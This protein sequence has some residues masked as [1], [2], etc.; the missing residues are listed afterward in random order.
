MER[1]PMMT[2]AEM[3]TAVRNMAR[4]IDELDNDL[5]LIR[6]GDD[7]YNLAEMDERIAILEGKLP[8]APAS[9]DPDA[10]VLCP[11]CGAPVRCENCDKMMDWVGPAAAIVRRMRGTR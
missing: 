4:K 6:A 5:I 7:M 9:D 2:F 11:N 3:E 8:P 10:P 1:E